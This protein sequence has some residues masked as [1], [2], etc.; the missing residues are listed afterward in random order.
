MYYYYAKNTG[1]WLAFGLC[2]IWPLI[3]HVI[4]LSITRRVKEHGWK[5]LIF[6]VDKHDQ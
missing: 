1:P 4:L 6:G 2:C 3:V 5:S